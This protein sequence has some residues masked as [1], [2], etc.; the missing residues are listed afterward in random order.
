MK[1]DFL[2]IAVCYSGP[3]GAVRG[4]P[5][6]GG[7]TPQPLGP[8]TQLGVQRGDTVTVSAFGYYAQPV[9]HGFFFTLGSFL[10]SLF[11]PAQA[12]A[13]GFEASKRKDLPLLQVGVAAGLSTISQIS[14]GVPKNF[15]SVPEA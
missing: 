1:P 4:P 2:S 7:S 8:L 6:R 14:G 3:L 12:P 5:Q 9:Q 11:H 15:Y 13:P 10:A